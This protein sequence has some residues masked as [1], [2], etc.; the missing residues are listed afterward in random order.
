MFYVMETSATGRE[1][2]ETYIIPDTWMKHEDSTCLWPPVPTYKADGMVKS[3][4]VPDPS[5]WRAFS[6]KILKA[7]R[8]KYDWSDNCV[9][10]H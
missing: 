5:T 3:R 1:E 7:A 4:K 2:S 9:F 8:K 6:V 10:N